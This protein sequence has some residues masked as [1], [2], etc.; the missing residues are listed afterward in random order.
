M[1]EW[2][3]AAD[4]DPDDVPVPGSKPR[5]VN[6]QERVQEVIDS[7]WD[8]RPRRYR[9]DGKEVELFP[10]GALATAIQRDVLTVRG[11]ERKG[12]F[13][14]PVLRAPGGHQHR[15]YTRRFIEGAIRIANE[16]G[17]YKPGTRVNKTDFTPRVFA[18][19][20]EVGG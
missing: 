17:L 19:F 9:V 2:D 20:Q 4:L 8:A 3:D 6:N 18:L 7:Q 15:L 1:S 11:W 12:W 10:I 5:R 13:P 14:A 16:E